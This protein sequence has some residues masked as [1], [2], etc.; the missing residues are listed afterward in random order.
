[1]E[2]SSSSLRSSKR[3]PRL[4]CDVGR[5]RPLMRT[6]QTFFL[7]VLMLSLLAAYTAMWAAIIRR[8]GR[9]PWLAA[10][11][12]IPGVNIIFLITLAVSEWPI[13]SELKQCKQRLH[14][15]EAASKPASQGTA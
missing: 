3:L 4:I 11:M 1:M 12:L 10:V 6:V 9:N 2:C 13:E 14:D 7:F 15:L 5:N 8:T